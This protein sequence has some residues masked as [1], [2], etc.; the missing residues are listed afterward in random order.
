MI[1]RNSEGIKVLR[2]TDDRGKG[3]VAVIF[4]GR[5]S[6]F[7]YTSEYS[8][9]MGGLEVEFSG[10]GVDDGAGDVCPFVGFVGLIEE[11]DFIGG[12]LR[13]RCRYTAIEAPRALYWRYSC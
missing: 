5:E 3:T 13:Q 2:G 4:F 6:G 12:L 8:Y 11:G 1:E 10:E 9:G 7:D